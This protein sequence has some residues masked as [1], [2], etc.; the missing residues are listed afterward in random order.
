MGTKLY[1]Y[2]MNAI[3][4]HAQA[5]EAVQ[6]TFSIAC[7]NVE[8]L[9]NS[10]N[11]NGWLMNVLKNV[12]NN[13][14]KKQARLFKMVITAISLE[15]IVIVTPGELDNVDLIYSDLLKP[16]E[17]ELLKKIVIDR[18]S[19]LE[20]AEEL[21]IS[22]EACKKRVQR[23]KKKLKKILEDIENDD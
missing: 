23:T 6:D 3:G 8:K 12:I 14:R 16:E 4:N 19:M 11:P 5:E 15:D 13:T 18:Y 22:V 9:L 17:F 1:V 10:D 7:S 2:A 20:A 21:G